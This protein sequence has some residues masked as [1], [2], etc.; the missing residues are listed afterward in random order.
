MLCTSE[1]CD[2][3]PGPVASPLLPAEVRFG[4]ARTEGPFLFKNHV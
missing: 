4:W 1:E 3:L 2:A